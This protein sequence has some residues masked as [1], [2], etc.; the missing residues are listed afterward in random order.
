MSEKSEGSQD[1]AMSQQTMPGMTPGELEKKLRTEQVY[2][3]DLSLT[4]KPAGGKGNK[5]ALLHA[6]V[7]GSIVADCLKHAIVA[8]R[9]NR[10]II[11]A[12]LG[13][14]ETAEGPAKS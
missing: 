14:P 2:E 6:K 1:A 8:D 3:V 10:A 9:R 13:N 5:V 7:R 11:E 4:L 12:I